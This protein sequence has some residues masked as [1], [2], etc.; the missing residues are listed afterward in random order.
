[1]NAD[2]LLLSRVQFA[3]TICF[4]YLFP[5]ITIGLAWLL[6]VI[7][8]LGWRRGDR[9]YDRIGI[10]FGK[11]LALTFAVGVATGIVMEFQFGMN[12]ARFAG[13]AG[14][15]FGIPLAAEGFFAFFLESIFMGLYLFGRRRVPRALHW[16]SVLMV[17]VGSSL[18]V[19]W[20]IAANSWQQTPDGY[21]LLGNRI[22]LVSFSDAIFNPSTMIRFLHTLDSSIITG[23]FFMGGISAYLLLKDR[24]NELARRTLSLAVVVG[25]V[26]AVLELMPL[27]HEHAVQVAATQPEKFAA[28]E[29]HNVTQANAP[30]VILALPRGDPPRMMPILEIPGLLGYLAF[31]DSSAVVRGLDAFPP[32]L[33]PPP[34]LTFFSFH[35]MVFL[36]LYFIALTG[37]TLLQLFRRRLY[38]NRT[39]LRIWFI[40]LPLPI[41]AGELGWITAEVGRQPWVIYRLLKT[42]DAHSLTVS[43]GEILFS[44][45][46]FS[47][48]YSLLG[49]L[50]LFLLVRKVKAGFPELAE[51]AG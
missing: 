48:I 8:F 34:V 24:Q 37:W 50:Y 39:L 32:D 28:L 42:A 47:F 4:H 33:L 51:G 38:Q 12:W 22:E 1:M 17:A 15:I 41:L 35:T 43:G 29:G 18:S 20:I 11:L 21:I 46:L 10:F 40:S 45:V 13:Q 25:F 3:L 6:V 49:G 19:F 30:M 27:G 16:F 31:G 7:E 26:A 44:I 2:P 23:A 36:G 14:D 9:A 5:P